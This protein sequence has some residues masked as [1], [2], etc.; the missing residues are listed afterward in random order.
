MQTRATAG[1]RTYEL[2]SVV[3]A[4]DDGALLTERQRECVTAA[5]RL[6][7]FEVPRRCTLAE[8]ADELGVDTSTASETIRRAVARVM[9]Q[10]L[11]GEES[12][13]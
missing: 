9:A 7:Y 4:A 12:V 1:E 2:L 3:H 5:L 10:F 8:G 13:A 11:L 6:G